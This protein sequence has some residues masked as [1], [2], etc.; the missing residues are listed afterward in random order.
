MNPNTTTTMSSNVHVYFPKLLL[1]RL[2]RKVVYQSLAS[3]STVIPKGAGVQ[4]KWLRYGE[5]HVTSATQYQLTEHVV[6][7]DS[8]ITTGNVTAT[9]AQYGNWASISDRLD[10]SAIDDVNENLVTL[11]ADEAAEQLEVVCISELDTNIGTTQFA[12]GKTSLANTGV[13]DVMTAKEILK[14]VITLKKDAVGPHESGSYVFVG[15]PACL[16]D[17][18]ND[19]NVGSWV[20]INNYT[21]EGRKSILNGETGMAYGCKILSSENVSSTTSGTLGSATVYTNHLFG[22]GSFGTVKLGKENVELIIGDAKTQGGPLRQYMTV[23]WKVLGFAAKYLG[24]SGNQTKERAVKI[25][26]GS[27]Y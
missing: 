4:V 20:S 26:A 23:G 6:P 13:N 17:I 18:Q 21:P 14:G 22:Q 27:G 1:D 25:R 11:L 9:T 10:F 3:K 12:N 7:V 8:Q 19:T 5:R 2:T 15:H 16:G 24:G